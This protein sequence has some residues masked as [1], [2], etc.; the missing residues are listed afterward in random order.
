MHLTLPA[1]GGDGSD[2]TATLLVI[3]VTQSDLTGRVVDH[4]GGKVIAMIVITTKTQ[5]CANAEVEV[6]IPVRKC[7]T[8]QDSVESTPQHYKIMY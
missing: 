6:R 5:N 2:N 1:G 3:L 4:G 7:T 8:C